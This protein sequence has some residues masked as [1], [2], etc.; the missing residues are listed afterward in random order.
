MT[1]RSRLERAAAW[2]VTGPMGHLLAGILDW[3]GLLCAYSFT[4]ARQA[5]A[6]SRRA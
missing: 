6:R 4:R 2:L 1:S 3:S 5:L